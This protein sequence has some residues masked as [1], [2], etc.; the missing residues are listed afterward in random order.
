MRN[1]SFVTVLLSIISIVPNISVA[2][3]AGIGAGLILGA[4]TGISAKFW[5]SNINAIDFAVGWSDDGEW[6][7]FGN[8]WYYYGLR[9]LHI[10]A[11]YL[12]HNYTAIKSQ[13]R[14]PLFYGVGFHYD[15]GHGAPSAFGMRGVIGIDWMP[16]AVP[17]DVFVEFAPVLFLTPGTGLG[18]DAGIGT[19]F[20]FH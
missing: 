5:T 1:L 16:R 12:W 15:D 6:A 19:R 13:E 18:L 9:Y 2:Q 11:D 3:G 8:T 7:R 14:F 17:I 10:H 4:P 20:F